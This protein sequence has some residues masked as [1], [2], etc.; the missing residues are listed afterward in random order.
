MKTFPG[1]S[2]R[3]AIYKRLDA[4]LWCCIWCI[5]KKASSLPSIYWN[6]QQHWTRIPC[7]M[8][9][10]V[11][12]RTL[13]CHIGP[14]SVRTILFAISVLASSCSSIQDR[15]ACPKSYTVFVTLPC[16]ETIYSTIRPVVYI[17]LHPIGHLRDDGGDTPAIQWWWCWCWY[18]YTFQRYWY[19]K[20][21]VTRLYDDDDADIERI[22]AVILRL[23]TSRRRKLEVSR[24][25]FMPVLN[26]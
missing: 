21:T 20:T 10:I 12:E 3:L 5:W 16:R 1:K 7:T 2:R 18:V 15:A 25:H 8:A 17:Q 24:S 11:D 26:P 6:H 23:S 9:I 22:N 19:W 13:V 4:R 14:E